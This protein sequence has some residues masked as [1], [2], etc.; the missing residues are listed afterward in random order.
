MSKM[1]NLLI[2]GKIKVGYQSRKDTYTG[3]LAYVIY[4]DGSGVLRKEKSWES[5]RDKKIDSQEYENKAIEGFVLNRGVGGTRESYGWNPRNEYIRVWDPRDFEFEI[6]VANLLFILGETSSIKGKGLEGEF[7]YSWSGTELVLL[8]VGSVEYKNCVEYTARQVKK[9]GRSEIKAG[10]I[11]RMKSGLEVMYI[12]N[13]P[14]NDYGNYKRWLPV[15]KKHIFLNIASGE[16]FTETGFKR[17]AEVIGLADNYGD[18]LDK[19]R[20]SEYYGEIDRVEV[21]RSKSPKL[22]W[23]NQMLIKEGD[24]YC[25]IEWRNVYYGYNKG[26]YKIKKSDLFIPEV[27]G[28]NVILPRA[29][30]SEFVVKED[31]IKELKCYD[32]EVVTKFG[33]KIALKVSY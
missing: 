18:E 5:W 28:N 2:P 30:G 29:N 9:V 19:F 23:N 13:Y 27:V 1:S 32:I 7:V 17:L 3:K 26:E 22:S 11:Y 16:Y 10:G 24:S 21:V 33:K 31:F 8:P 15:G 6:S 12:G 25:L 14:Y 4:F 20:E